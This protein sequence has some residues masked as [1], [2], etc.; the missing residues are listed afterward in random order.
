MFEIRLPTTGSRPARKV[1][2]DQRLGQRQL[3]AEQ[4]EHHDQVE[5][6]EHGVERRDAHLGEDDAPERVAEAA[7]PLGQ[8]PASGRAA[9]AGRA[10]CSETRA[11]MTMPI[12]AW[13]K[14]RPICAP[15]ICSSPAC[16]RSHGD[17]F[18]LQL[19]GVVGDLGGE[20]GGEVLPGGLE[21]V[22][23]LGRAAPAGSP[24]RRGRGR[25]R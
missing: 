24:V 19:V 22:R 11:P 9:R 3:D 2:D 23:H 6:G 4:G 16:S 18:V 10:S 12:S 13:T 7:G 1:S 14:T 5:G 8:R 15:K 20:P 25:T 21:D 17:P